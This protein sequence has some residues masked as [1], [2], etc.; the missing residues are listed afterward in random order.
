M[1]RLTTIF[2]VGLVIL[3]AIAVVLG[4]WAA[5]LMGALQGVTEFLPI[6]SSGH[7]ILLPWLFGWQDPL[8]NS[9]TFDVALHIG[10]L[11]AVIAYFWSDWMALLNAVPY[12]ARPQQSQP[13]MMLWM[14]IIATIPAA[15]AGVLFQKPIEA[16]FRSPL[17]IAVL[18][19]VMGVVIALIDRRSTSDRELPSMTWRDAIWIGLA[20]TLALMPG[21]S[22]SGATMSAGRAL[23]LDRAAAARFSFLLSMPITLAAVVMKLKDL[24]AMHGN[25]IVAVVIGIVTSAM[26]G[27]LVIDLMIQWIRRI[28]FGWF[29]YYRIVMAIVVLGFWYIRG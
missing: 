6:S 26:V 5:F 23:R 18:L 1:T 10:T 17:Q 3:A 27:W 19:A 12:L 14:V 25:E 4:H 29:A 20:Q 24:L 22:R 15:I 8:L 9:L 2:A 21:V 11:V 16:Y 7:L 28:G 13:A